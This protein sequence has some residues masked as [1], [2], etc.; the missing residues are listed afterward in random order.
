MLQQEGL[1][2]FWTQ[3]VTC[4][5]ILFTEVCKYIMKKKRLLESKPGYYMFLYTVSQSVVGLINHNNDPEASSPADQTTGEG[6][7]RN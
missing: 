5:N 6:E 3:S 4:K 2:L 1:R 7:V